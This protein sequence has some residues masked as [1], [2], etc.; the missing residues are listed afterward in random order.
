MCVRFGQTQEQYAMS[1]KLVL[2]K[3]FVIDP[4]GEIIVVRQHSSRCYW[5]VS[6]LVQGHLDM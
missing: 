5:R 6:T 2:K 1:M 3:T 4:F